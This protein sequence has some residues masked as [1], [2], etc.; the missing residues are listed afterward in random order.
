WASHHWPDARHGP[1]AREIGPVKG[2]L[3]N[4][5]GRSERISTTAGA[6]G[7]NRLR[8]GPAGGGSSA[9]DAGS[10]GRGATRPSNSI[11]KLSGR[12]VSSKSGVP[13]RRGPSRAVR[14]ARVS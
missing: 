10:S 9:P 12:Y 4:S 11:R 13:T 1:L 8:G 2:P 3:R 5:A 7:R 6:G 14:R